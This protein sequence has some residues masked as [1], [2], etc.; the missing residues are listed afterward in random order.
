MDDPLYEITPEQRRSY[1]SLPIPFAIFRFF[2]GQYTTVLLS[3]GLCRMFGETREALSVFLGDHP[4]KSLHPGDRD[5][6]LLDR[7]A[8]FLRPDGEFRNTYRISATGKTYVQVLAHGNF[9]R[10]KDGSS[11]VHIV[12]L[13][14]EDEAERRR[15]EVAAALR[16]EALL[17]NILATTSTCIFWKDAERRFLGVNKA[18]LD[19]YGFE[20][21][22][23]LIGRTDEDMGWHPD[24]YENDEARILREGMH[25][26]RV[27]GKC[28]VRGELRDIV[29]SES[30][31]IVDGKIVGLVGS[32][33]DVTTG[34]R[35]QR[36]ISQL[37]AALEKQV[38]RM[39]G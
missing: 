21:E 32:F 29:I 38:M 14:T 30:P 37:N 31:L 2:E 7:S 35:Q 23:V 12:Y 8:A 3:D 34:M 18:F 10:L 5:N 16:Q 13:P 24:P 17:A 15:Q 1:E 6:L 9:K 28:M 36:E 20:N 19:Y 27:P 33:E 26:C 11:L 39:T 25:T 4:E 22:E